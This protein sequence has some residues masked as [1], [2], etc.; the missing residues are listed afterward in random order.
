LAK[1]SI[2]GYNLISNAEVHMPFF[3]LL[4]LVITGC[5]QPM[6]QE[7]ISDPEVVRKIRSLNGIFQSPQAESISNGRFARR[8]LRLSP[9]RYEYTYEVFADSEMKKPLFQFREEGG[10]IF[11]IDNSLPEKSYNFQLKTA[12]RYLTVHTKDKKSQRDLGFL[13]CG[14]T[15]KQEKDIS[16]EGCGLYAEVDQCANQYDV[17]SIEDDRLRLGQ[18]PAD[19]NICET[20]RRPTELGPEL[21]RQK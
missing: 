13:E 4:L 19:L 21:Q 7:Q 6:K 15:A 11:A 10:Y 17:I 8:G 14:L 12:K 18:R 5:S 9:T 16:L 1:N 2:L 20:F 3:V